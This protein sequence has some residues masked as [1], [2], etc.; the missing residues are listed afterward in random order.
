MSFSTEVTEWAEWERVNGREKNCNEY[1]QNPLPTSMLQ[2]D[3]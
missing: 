1:S 3:G 2:V